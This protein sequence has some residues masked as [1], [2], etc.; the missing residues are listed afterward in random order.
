MKKAALILAVLFFC[1][2]LDAQENSFGIS[3]HDYPRTTTHK[4][5]TFS[6]PGYANTSCNGSVSMNGFASG[7]GNFS[8]NGT[9]SNTCNTCST[10]YTPS[11]TQNNDVQKP[12]VYILAESETS[13]IV[14][15]CT[16]NVRWSQC[17]S[18]NHGTFVAR[19]NDGHFEVQAVLGIG[20]E[21]WL[22]FDRVQQTAMSGQQPQ[23]APAP[24]PETAASIEAP[25]SEA[26][27]TESGFPGRWKSM[28]SGAVRTLRVEGEYVYAEVVLPDAQAKA[29]MFVL[30]EAKKDG[31]KYV[32]K[33][34]KRLLNTQTGP[35]CSVTNPIESTLV[36][37]DRIEG[38][39]FVSPPSE[40]IDWNTCS[41]SSP[42]DWQPFVWIPVRYRK[43]DLQ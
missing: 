9:T 43:Q 40:K 16:R 13:R 8:T 38:R 27:N 11:G 34:S 4:T 41:Y 39:V 37:P 32:G 23:T 2:V 10:S 19:L 7:G 26:P 14:P 15:T 6:W 36:T 35:S 12:V 42:S 21:E 31:E 24:V 30:T 1:R 22:R 3:V 18:L 5:L 25:K 28:N 33:T 20:K 17:H 29:G